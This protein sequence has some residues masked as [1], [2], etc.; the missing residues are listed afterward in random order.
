MKENDVMIRNYGIHMTW[1]T[2]MHD[3]GSRGGVSDDFRLPGDRHDVETSVAQKNLRLKP[4]FHPVVNKVRTI[5]ER[6]FFFQ[7]KKQSSGWL[8]EWPISV[9]YFCLVTDWLARS[10]EECRSGT[11]RSGHLWFLSISTPQAFW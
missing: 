11:I 3:S 5:R 9:H 1:I 2:R 10:R 4:L 6:R 8:K 7:G